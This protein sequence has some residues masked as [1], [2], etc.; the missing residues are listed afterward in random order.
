MSREQIVVGVDGSASSR[1]ALSWAAT[2]ARS[3][4]AEI[5]AVH[6][7]GLLEHLEGEIP[8]ASEANRAEIARVF[9]ERWCAPLGE[10]GLG[11]RRL[12][13]DGPVAEVL[14]AVTE[15]VGADLLVV[16][17]RAASRRPGRLLAS[18]SMQ[19]AARAACP[20][21]IVP[22]PTAVAGGSARTG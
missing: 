7:M 21:L 20:L 5:T 6:A 12:L 10:H 19:V 22:E 3:L 4:A 9:E 15:E 1:A 11:C 14:L 16:G 13:R 17:A 18:T 2:L 8:V